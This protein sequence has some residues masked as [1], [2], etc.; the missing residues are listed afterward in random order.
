MRVF[1]L[2]FAYL[3][4]SSVYANEQ[5]AAIFFEVY[6]HG[7]LGEMFFVSGGEKDIDEIYKD[8]IQ[9]RVGRGNSNP[10]PTR[11]IKQIA[12]CKAGWAALVGASRDGQD[13]GYHGGWACHAKSAEQALM[14]AREQCKTKG[15][16]KSVYRTDIYVFFVGEKKEKLIYCRYS[17]GELR[18]GGELCGRN[19]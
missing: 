11:W 12:K 1:V 14:L 5:G 17:R 2:F 8:E 6:N 19:F 3:I 4:S 10:S 18:E 13:H 15:E 16:C 7:E 9:A